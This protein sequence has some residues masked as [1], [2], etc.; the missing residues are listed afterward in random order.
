MSVEIFE[1]LLNFS[2]EHIQENK[3]FLMRLIFSWTNSFIIQIKKISEDQNNIF[4]RREKNNFDLLNISVAVK[5]SE[6][7]NSKKKKKISTY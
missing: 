5:F 3:I 6:N 4:Y 2:D 1:L 7:Q